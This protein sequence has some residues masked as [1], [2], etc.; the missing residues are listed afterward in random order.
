MSS[1]PSGFTGLTGFCPNAAEQFCSDVNNID[2]RG[3]DFSSLPQL[4][5]ELDAMMQYFDGTFDLVVQEQALVELQNDLQTVEYLLDR[6][7]AYYPT[8]I[9]WAFW[10]AVGCNLTLAVVCGL[11]S[12]SVML[13]YF[14]HPLPVWLKALRSYAM[15]PIFLLLV[16]LGWIF[17][18]IFIISAIGFADACI[19]S[20]DAVMMTILERLQGEFS[21]NS[22]LY[23]FFAYY[24]SGCPVQMAP[25][26]LEQRYVLTIGKVRTMK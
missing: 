25:Q 14:G 4:Q 9:N 17:S 12:I 8:T 13:L 15:V 6:A 22:V 7:N 24:I 2:Q 16:V 21:T 20:P 5:S 18:S 10:V 3:C 26:D 11:I 1:F 23:D 19:N